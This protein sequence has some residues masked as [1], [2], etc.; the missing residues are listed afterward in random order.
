MVDDTAARFDEYVPALQLWHEL[1]PTLDHC[2]RMHCWHVRADVAPVN[3]DDNPALH[4][5]Q[6]EADGEPIDVE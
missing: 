1:D 6:A 5:R 2:P 3:G 4:D